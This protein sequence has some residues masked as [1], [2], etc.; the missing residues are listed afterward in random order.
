[1]SFNLFYYS[2]SPGASEYFPYVISIENYF[3][4]NLR[5]EKRKSRA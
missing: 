4:V 1:M 3:D 2:N 5:S